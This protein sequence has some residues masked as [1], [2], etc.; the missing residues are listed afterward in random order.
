MVFF[1]LGLVLV[2]V[3]VLVLNM[4]SVHVLSLLTN[5]DERSSGDNTSGAP[6]CFASD[7]QYCVLI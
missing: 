1:F 5:N 4:V 2:L 6:S 3:L 7:S